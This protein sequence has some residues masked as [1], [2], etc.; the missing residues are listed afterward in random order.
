MFE[1]D[2]YW[3]LLTGMA[4]LAVVVWIALTRI[5]AP[6]GIMYRRGWGPGLDNRVGW[7]LMEAPAF[8]AMAL[9]MLL[10]P[11]GCS[12]ADCAAYVC[13]GLFLLHYF[14][15]SFIFPLLMRGKSRMPLVIALMGACF[16]IIN[17]YLIGGWLFYLSPLSYGVE[18]LTSW[19]F[20]AGLL[21][22][23]FGMGCNWQADYIVRHLRKPGETRHYIP[24]G[25]VFRFVTAGSYFGEI[26]EWAGFALLTCSWAGAVFLLW[27]M[28]NLV[29][30]AARLHK[31]YMREFGNEY[32]SLGRR[33]IIPF[34]Y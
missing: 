10:S 1:P 21:I 20:L 16:N 23:G 4:V 5:E 31:R 15:R 24:R 34:I 2:I 28:A 14:R 25:G 12:A 9:L 27:T 3:G 6:Y 33:R 26:V 32:K 13:G 29:P 17:V 7:V 11:Q 8:V 18:W 22:F 30:R 19:Q